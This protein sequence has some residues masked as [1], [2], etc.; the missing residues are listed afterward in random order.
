M[1]KIIKSPCCPP[2]QHR[3]TPDPHP[4][5]FNF[6][7]LLKKW[8]DPP[9]RLLGTVIMGLLVFS[10]S[11]I[12]AFWILAFS[13]LGEGYAF[14]AIVPYSY[15]V[16][17]YVSLL[18]FFRLK[19]FDYF[20]FT[21]LTMLLVLPFFMQWVVGGFEASGGVAIWGILSPV[22]AL[23]I[24]GVRQSTPWFV[25]FFLLTVVSYALDGLFASHALPIPRF[26]RDMFFFANIAGAA[27]ILYFVMR[28]F[29]SQKSR[30]MSDLDEKHRQLLQEQ[31]KSEHLLLNILPKSV[32]ERLKNNEELIADSH[33]AVTI[34]F[35]DLVNFTR[36]SIEM[37]PATLLALLNQVFSRFDA[38]VEKY[39]LE[40][41]K[42]IG[43]AYMVVGGAPLPRPDHAKAVALLAL[44]MQQALAEISV[45][46]GIPL[47][48]RIGINSGPVIAGVIG[49]SKFSYD[50]WGDT[51]NMASRMEQ[52]GVAG[53]IQISASTYALLKDK[54]TTEARGIIAIK[55]D[56]NVEAYLLS[57]ETPPT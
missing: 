47:K 1:T 53:G 54:F 10:E 9:A 44:D 21:Q 30:A 36:L 11:L 48:M 4:Q 27:S 49:H 14:M 3:T 37:P 43:D 25:L 46:N 51:V 6:A 28:F 35:A 50:L 22:G 31:E 18:L 8:K 29:E 34:L 52:S 7:V 13:G 24:L 56:G 40:K 2:D 16:I 39:G 45:A 19:R 38:L 17:S 26:T 33:A 12:S 57:Q 23:M 55:G 5:K 41:I 42:T 20:I 32:A 15:L